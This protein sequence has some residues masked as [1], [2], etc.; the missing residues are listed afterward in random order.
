MDIAYTKLSDT[1]E[2][3]AKNRY[4]A[5]NCDSEEMREKVNKLIEK[6]IKEGLTDEEQEYL[7]S[8]KED[9]LGLSRRVSRVLASAEKG[10]N[11]KY[12]EDRFFK[13]LISRKALPNSPTLMNAG[14][15]LNQLSACYVLIPN[16]SMEDIFETVKHQ[17]LIQKSGGN[18]IN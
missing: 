12:W 13:L 6:K 2:D 5:I 16:D 15:P 14:Q 10:E 7:D 3:L 9:W 17:A 4:Y 1:A 11:R 8:L 18:H